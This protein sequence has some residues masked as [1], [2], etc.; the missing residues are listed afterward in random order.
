[1]WFKDLLDKAY[2]CKHHW[3][4]FDDNEEHS[5]R[6]LNGVICW[7][8]DR[9]TYEADA[10]HVEAVLA[11]LQLNEAKAVTSPGTREDQTKAIEI[12]S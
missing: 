7:S 9:I 8:Q 6:V 12:V 10:R 11:Q 4:G 5:I 1:M 2:E 3:L